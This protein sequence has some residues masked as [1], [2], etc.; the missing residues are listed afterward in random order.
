M[1]SSAERTARIRQWIM[2]HIEAHP[3]DLKPA[4]AAEFTLSPAVAQR[5]IQKLVDS[6][7]LRALG[8]SRRP[9]YRP[10]LEINPQLPLAGLQEDE[11]WRLY[12]KEAL[13]YLPPNVLRL[14]EYGL[15]GILNNAI[16]HSEGNSVLLRAIV[17]QQKIRFMVIDDGLGIFAKI[18]TALGLNDPQQ[19]CLELAK[20]KVTTSP[21]RHNGEGLFFTSRSF[22]TFDI[23][24][25][26]LRF[27]HNEP[28]GYWLVE[29][30][31]LFQTGTAVIL[32]IATQAPQQIEELFSRYS[33]DPDRPRFDRTVIPVALTRYGDENLLSRS[34]ARR[35]V[36]R[37]ESFR[38]V[39]LDFSGI[40]NL[41]P[42][43]ADEIFR[44]YHQEH[45]EVHLI[46]FNAHPDVLKMIFRALNTR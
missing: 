33:T 4:L 42:D 7:A 38:Q 2:A 22:D 20:G 40:Q 46:P 24:S 44:V 36:A 30:N 8:T 45:P 3:Y 6:E 10:N 28:S 1:E 5:Q 41:G 19:T 13:Q 11:V 32:E 34:Q 9:E 12:F 15:T 17:T 14:C 26:H 18:Q 37:L 21:D 27:S 25:H 43:F 23:V 31:P 39:I 35:L 16:Q 29:E